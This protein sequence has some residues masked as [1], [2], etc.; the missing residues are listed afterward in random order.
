MSKHKL[1][2]LVVCVFIASFVLLNSTRLSFSAQTTCLPEVGEKCKCDWK[3]VMVKCSSLEI[4]LNIV[5]T[6]FIPSNIKCLILKRSWSISPT[7]LEARC[8]EKFHDI[9]VL[10]F[11]YNIVE[12]IKPRSFKLV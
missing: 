6:E 3:R 12:A 4:E 10:D 9:Q 11:S 2:K 1:P 8:L 7:I 5:L